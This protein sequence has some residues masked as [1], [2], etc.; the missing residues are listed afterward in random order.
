MS[1]GVLSI[2]IWYKVSFVGQDWMDNITSG[3][4][5][6]YYEDMYKNR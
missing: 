5:E 3:D 2:K 1:I 4:Y 6:R